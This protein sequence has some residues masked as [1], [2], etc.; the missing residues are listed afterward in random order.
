MN[1]GSRDAYLKQRWILEAKMD[2]GSKDGYPAFTGQCI[3]KTRHVSKPTEKKAK[4]PKLSDKQE[5]SKEMNR[6]VGTQDE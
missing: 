3:R 2:T 1:T 6:I 4:S 5:K